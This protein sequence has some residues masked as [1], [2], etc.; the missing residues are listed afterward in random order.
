ML[1]ILCNFLFKK[2]ILINQRTVLMSVFLHLNQKKL[3]INVLIINK[4]NLSIIYE[5][6]I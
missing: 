2:Q 4:I 6:R 3:T 1:I 5:R